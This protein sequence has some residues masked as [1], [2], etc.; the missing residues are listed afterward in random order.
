[1]HRFL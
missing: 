1:L